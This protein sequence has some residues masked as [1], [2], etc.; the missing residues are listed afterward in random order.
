MCCCS[1]LSFVWLSGTP[2]TATYQAYLFFIVSQSLLK[3]MSIDSVIPSNHLILCHPLL[4]LPSQSFPA[5][6]SFPMS[7]LFT[8]GGQSIGASASSFQWI[9]R[10][11]FLK[12]WLVWSLCYPRDSQE[13]SPAPQFERINSSVHCLL[14]DDVGKSNIAYEPR[15]LGPWIKSNWKWSTRRW[16]E[17]TLTF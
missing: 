14:C 2:W 4:L 6:G 16:Q 5:S 11:D 10:V 12:D 7:Q 13:S 9:F 15:M 3:L 8:S 1:A 17:W